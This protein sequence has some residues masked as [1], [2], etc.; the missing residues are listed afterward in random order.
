[1]A[2]SKRRENRLNYR[3]VYVVIYSTQGQKKAEESQRWQPPGAERVG[4]EKKKR[5][6]GRSTSRHGAGIKYYIHKTLKSPKDYG[7][8]LSPPQNPNLAHTD[9][10]IHTHHRISNLNASRGGSS[11]F[12]L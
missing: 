10:L 7:D 5:V 2:P 11:K 12:K 6:E 9:Y 1:M 3:I 8:E 4:G